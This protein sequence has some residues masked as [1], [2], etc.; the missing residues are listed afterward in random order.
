MVPA[1]RGGFIAAVGC[2]LVHLDWDTK[3]VIKLQES[4]QK[5]QFNDGKCDPQG[6]VWAGM[7]Q[8]Y[9]YVFF[10]FKLISLK[11]HIH[12]VDNTHECN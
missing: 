3:K 10:L 4:D 12:K 5:L 6:R 1:R 7:L 11:C 2:C 9:L 8:L